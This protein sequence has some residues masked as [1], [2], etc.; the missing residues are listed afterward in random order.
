MSFGIQYLEPTTEPTFSPTTKQP[1][2]SPIS[3]FPLSCNQRLNGTLES[4]PYLLLQFDLNTDRRVQLSACSNE[5]R[6]IPFTISNGNQT[7]NCTEDCCNGIIR[8]LTAGNYSI[9]VD[10]IASQAF[11]SVPFIFDIDCISESPTMNPTMEPT[12]EPTTEPTIDPTLDPTVDPTSDP[13]I[14]PTMDPTFEPTSDPTSDPT[15]DPTID[16][17]MDPSIDP[18]IDPTIDPTADP[19]VDPTQEP[20][21]DP[22]ID[23]TVDPTMDPSIDPSIDPTLDPTNDPTWDPSTD[24]TIDPTTEPTMEPTIEPTT[25]PSM[26]PTMSPITTNDIICSDYISGIF[27]NEAI[28]YKLQLRS[29]RVVTFDACDS[30]IDDWIIIVMDMRNDTVDECECCELTT[31]LSAGTY[32][33][34]FDIDPNI[35][36]NP[37]NILAYNISIDC[38]SDS[39]TF[40]PT[41]EPT[42]EPTMEPTN[43]M[44]QPPNQGSNNDEPT[45]SIYLWV[46]IGTTGCC[47]IILIALLIMYKT[48]RN[49]EELE[50]ITTENLRMEDAHRKSKSYSNDSDVRDDSELQRFMDESVSVDQDDYQ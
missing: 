21:I 40:D 37:Q 36:Y 2:L 27:E 4:D 38:E 19:T 1:T 5:T 23:P 10:S 20:T 47:C 49:S 22:T 17:T 9:Q 3:T 42:T 48:K 6:S 30:E 24:P 43:S 44:N 39:P 26:E 34:E 45:I 12:A 31:N 41:I 50:A 16:P 18:S 14:D 15:N 35:M 28:I 32:H 7:I 46:I 11:P 13:T 33:F 25:D 29:S 8:N